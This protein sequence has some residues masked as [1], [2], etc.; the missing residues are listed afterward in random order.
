MTKIYPFQ[1]TARWL[2]L[3]FL[4]VA[5]LL[6]SWVTTSAQEKG[7]P[8]DP[9]QVDP[10]LEKVKQM[11]MTHDLSS[12][13]VVVE[14]APAGIEPEDLSPHHAMLR[15]LEGH[16]TCQGRAY[17]VPGAAAIETRGVARNSLILGDSALQ[18]DFKGSVQGAPFVG[19]GLDGYDVDKGEHYSAWVDS[20]TTGMSYE[21][22]S[23]CTH[24]EADVV[25]YHG[26]VR[27]AETGHPIKTRTKLTVRTNSTYTMEQWFVPEDGE[28]TPSMQ[29]IFTRQQEKE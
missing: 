18:M 10:R 13:E 25:T 3:G 7:E 21:T 23:N 15:K 12:G 26:E 4:M 24:G 2:S 1:T 19:L 8:E 27:H 28:E 17:P 6:G 9:R 20:V 29:I 14:E 11:K 16:W 22:G 5:L